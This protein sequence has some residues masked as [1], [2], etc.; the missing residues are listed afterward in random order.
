M[1]LN[2]RVKFVWLS[3][4][5]L[6]LACVW[7]VVMMGYLIIHPE[8][9]VVEGLSNGL[10]LFV[11]L[12]VVSL[13]SLAATWAWASL[14]YNGF[15]YSF[16]EKEAV[17]EQGIVGKKKTVV[18][19][20]KVK[21]VRV[22]RS[23]IHFI[24]QIF[25]ISTLRIDIGDKKAGEVNIPGVSDAQEVIWIMTSK[26]QRAGLEQAKN[27]ENSPVE[28]GLHGSGSDKKLLFEILEELK[29][30]RKALES[31]KEHAKQPKEPAKDFVPMPIDSFEG[32]L[33]TSDNLHEEKHAR[34]SK[35]EQSSEVRSRIEELTRMISEKKKKK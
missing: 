34:H 2:P 12:S 22:V 23:G 21:E 7:F 26:N 20:D 4:A 18:P 9:R 17:I 24:D 30:I 15:D 11:V 28:L 10:L 6:A 35:G 33:R 19:Y 31:G 8:D 27:A 29:A 16:G 14:F 32:I 5:L 25:G 13:V 1:K 3:E